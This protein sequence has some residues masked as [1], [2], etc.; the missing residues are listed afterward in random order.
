MHFLFTFQT[1]AISKKFKPPKPQNKPLD[2]AKMLVSKKSQIEKK[3]PT[4]KRTGSSDS[5]KN[6]ISKKLVKRKPITT[7]QPS[8]V[9]QEKAFTSADSSTEMFSVLPESNKGIYNT[10]DS[11]ALLSEQSV[12]LLKTVNSITYTDDSSREVT[13]S[14]D[15]TEN[16][17]EFPVLCEN[18]SSPP[19]SP[20]KKSS[21]RTSP[22]KKSSLQSSPEN[23]SIPQTSLVKKPSPRSTS[24][25][26][27]SVSYYFKNI[28]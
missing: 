22:A 8:K 21:L 3:L 20:A 26:K 13:S 7:Q 27:S 18:K 25:K 5:P 4:K 9:L 1:K 11:T 16:I 12:S 24:A 19:M 15:F 17:P 23:K 2:D 14:A 6:K 28:I 10:E